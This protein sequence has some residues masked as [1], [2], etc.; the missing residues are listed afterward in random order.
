[1]EFVY[2]GRVAWKFDDF[3]AGDLILGDRMGFRESDLSRLK[4]YVLTDFKRDFPSKFHK[5]DL[6]VAGRY[7]GGTRDHGGMAALQALGV[8]CVVAESF[9]RPALRKCITYAF[10]VLEC[11][12]ISKL[13][14]RGDE[15]EVN[16]MT[17]EVKNLTTGRALR[18]PPAH[19]AQLEILRDGGFVP[20]LKKKLRAEREMPEN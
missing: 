7:F 9:G 12:G 18:A 8:A 10:P 16:L 17:G 6:M 3:F 2:R 15:L 4:D 1:M 19:E 11:A 20:Y 5:G 14:G 13:A